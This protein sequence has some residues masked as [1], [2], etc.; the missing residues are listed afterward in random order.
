MEECVK[1]ARTVKDKGA[2]RR[3]YSEIKKVMYEKVIDDCLYRGVNPDS[4]SFMPRL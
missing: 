1:L 4:V 3:A 2:H